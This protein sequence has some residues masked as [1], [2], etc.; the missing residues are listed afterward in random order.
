VDAAVATAFALAVTFP[1]AGNIGGG[2]FLLYRPV[3]GEPAG[4]DF[5][6]T[7]PA[8]AGPD[9]FLAD[10]EY[11]STLHHRSHVAVGVPGTVAGLHLAWKEQGRLSW[12]RLV[13]PS[14]KLAK[15][16]FVVSDALA[17]SLES[18]LPEMRRYPA[19][20]AAFTRNGEPYRMG[21]VLKQPDLART[22]SRIARKGPSGFYEGETALLIER[23]M[24][25][26]GGLIRRGD[27]A[28]YRAI[29]RQPL[30]GTYRGHE[31]LGM[32]PPTSGGTAVI[33]ILNILEG[34]DLASMGS[35]SAAMVHHTAEAMR[36]AFADRA[37]FLG[38][39]DFNPGM[40]VGRL[41]SKEHAAG[42][43]G[44]I[45]PVKAS[46]SSP[47]LFEWPR[48][49][50]ET[51]HLSVVDSARN[52]VALTYTLEQNHGSK[53]VVPG[54]GFLLNNEMGDFNP[55][56]GQTTAEGR[57]GTKPNLAAAGKRML[58]SMSPTI[59]SEDGEVLLV[60]GAAGGRTIISTVVL[61]ILNVVDF[62]MNAQEAID[63]PRFH[64][65]WLPNVI[66]TEV[67]GLS[68]D[69]VSL[70]ESRGHAVKAGYGRVDYQGV[71]EAIVHRAGEGV[72]EAGCDRR[73]AGGAAAGY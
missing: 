20:V 31:I 34:F 48:A 26:G 10:G 4:Y 23:E 45:D 59:V 44:T 40:P 70:L 66:R 15:R 12:K 55:V 60:T 37:R 7:A 21:D 47:G 27:L 22:L 64:H 11:D 61:T 25:R 68:P 30:R 56:P 29:R 41:V 8:A 52:A 24:E 19:S 42:L 36:R 16:G 14:V 43:R 54:A 62:G 38:D 13:K 53:I 18:N 46:V 32:P 1:E 57:I 65:Q 39:P 72:L 63:A 28:G 35:G 69:T 2:G 5:R 33:E 6:E 17:R 73:E 58:S 9:M 67:R 50:G 49:G 71:A 3:K 51:T